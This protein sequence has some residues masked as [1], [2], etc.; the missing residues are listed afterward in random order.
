MAKKQ[1]KKITRLRRSGKYHPS[2]NNQSKNFLKIYWP[3]IPMLVV[4]FA[5]LLITFFQP[6]RKVAQNAVLS[7][8][9]EMTRDGL[10]SGHN[11]N[12]ASGGLAPLT[13]NSLLNQAAQN[14]ANDMKARDYWSH[15]TPDG[16]EPWVFFDQVGY[17]YLKAGENLAYGFT[18]SSATVQG[19]MNSAGHR[20]NIMDANFTE[21]G[22][23]FI[24]IPNYVGS[25]EETLVV[26]EYGKPR[27]VATPAPTPTPPAAPTPVPTVPKAVKTPTS[28]EPA[29]V[30]SEVI[31]NQP[32]DKAVKQP[33]P[34][35]T[36]EIVAFSSDLPAGTE[37][38][39]TQ[40]TRVQSWTNGAAPWSAAVLA[41]ISF[42][43]SGLWL[44]KHARAV[45]RVLIH[46][47]ELVLHHPIIDVAVVVFI[48]LVAYLTMTTGIV[49]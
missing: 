47:E 48:C 29:N 3:Y 12:R 46:G 45:K 33:E 30:P 24:D 31:I 23:G 18:T 40:V 38:A 34:E 2:K 9:T 42:T 4:A 17:R 5:G 49:K 10:L 22:F 43:I 25:G 26:A 14:K 1:T 37:R 15:N 35:K 39:S 27:T 41:V 21:V 28:T 36:S 32:V 20:A 13:I 19:W 44:G 16:Q 8:A 6:A 7:Y 11:S